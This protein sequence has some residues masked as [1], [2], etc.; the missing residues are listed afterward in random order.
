MVSHRELGRVLAAAFLGSEWELDAMA[1]RGRSAVGR[2]R[3]VRSV[4]AAVLAA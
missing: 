3:W 4:A 2:R 1:R